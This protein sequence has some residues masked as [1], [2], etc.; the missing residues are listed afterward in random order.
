MRSCRA[1]LFVVVLLLCFAACSGSST[2]RAAPPSTS[3]PVADY[4]HASATSV[5]PN[6]TGSGPCPL[7]AGR[8]IAGSSSSCYPISSS[9]GFIPEPV[10]PPPPCAILSH[11][12]VATLPTNR[13]RTTIGVAEDVNISSNGDGWTTTGAGLVNAN[14]GSAVTL[15]GG[16]DA[17]TVTVTANGGDTDACSGTASVTFTVIAPSGTTY[18]RSGPTA[19]IAGRPYI[20]MNMDLYLVP[21]TVSFQNLYF[22][23]LDANVTASGVWNCPFI[24]NSGHSPNPDP[25]QVLPIAVGIG[26]QVAGFDTAASGDCGDPPPFESSTTSVSIPDVYVVGQTGPRSSPYTYVTQQAILNAAGPNGG[27]LILIKGN[28]VANAAVNGPTVNL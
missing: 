25:T 28:A 13:T 7:I 1:S 4:R 17:G 20:A 15:S 12:T 21:P 2:L 23:E 11:T 14:V 27:T 8:Q 9:G 24:V 18:V 3:V 19:H 22:L 10:P 16:A 5:R 26:S 6:Y